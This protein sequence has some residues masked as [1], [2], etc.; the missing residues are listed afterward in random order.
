MKTN[1]FTPFFKT[2][3]VVSLAFSLANCSK[4]DGPDT[5]Q[6]QAFVYNASSGMSTGSV[7]TAGTPVQAGYTWSEVKSP[8]T[9]WGINGTVNDRQITDDFQ[10]PSGEKWNIENF[11]FYAYQ[12]GF[13][14]ATFPVNEFYYEIYSSDPSVAGA[15]K[16]YGDV[17]TNR[18]VSA[19]DSKFLRILQGQ[20]DGNTRVVYKMKIQAT[21]LNLTAGTYWIKWSSKTSS[22]THFYAHLPHDPARVNNASQFD[23]ATTTWNSLTDAGQRVSFPMDITGTKLPN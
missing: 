11:Y 19:E 10:V 6:P 20:T 21:G 5:P 15:V 2:V 4:D 12:T 8:Q 16:I 13:A 3:L 17:T 22:G 18:F 1:F 9:T 23:V 14:G 7:S